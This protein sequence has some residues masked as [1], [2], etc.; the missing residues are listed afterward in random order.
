MSGQHLAVILALQH[1][2]IKNIHVH[3]CGPVGVEGWY[4]C[5][6][7]DTKNY[8]TMENHE[9]QLCYFSINLFN[10]YNFCMKTFRAKAII[11]EKYMYLD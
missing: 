1:R 9:F 5:Q 6:K 8:T 11:S 10:F 4:P 3:Q 7:L 2:C